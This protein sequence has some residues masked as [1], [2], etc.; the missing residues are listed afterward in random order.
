MESSLDLSFHQSAKQTTHSLLEMFWG[1][2]NESAS[3][4]KRKSN[5]IV[6]YLTIGVYPESSLI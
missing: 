4:K 3:V 5:Y 1:K 6:E 2:R